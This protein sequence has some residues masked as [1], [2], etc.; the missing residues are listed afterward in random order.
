M[1]L[2]IIVEDE[3]DEIIVSRREM[4]RVLERKLSFMVFWLYIEWL[5]RIDKNKENLVDWVSYYE[6]LS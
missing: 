5:K 2:E 1:L 3:K 4:R 6:I